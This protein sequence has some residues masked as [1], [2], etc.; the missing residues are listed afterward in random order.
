MVVGS[1]TASGLRLFELIERYKIQHILQS[2]LLPTIAKVNVGKKHILQQE[3]AACCIAKIR[4][5]NL[6]N[7]VLQ[8]PNFTIIQKV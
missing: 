8:C 7:T 5:S 3:G 4:K 1:I 2:S 6:A